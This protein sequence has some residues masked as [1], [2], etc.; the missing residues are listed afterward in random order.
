[1]KIGFLGLLALIFITLKLTGYIT[2]AWVWILSP[3]WIGAI[4]A[5]FIII[6]VMVY[7]LVF[8]SGPRH[9]P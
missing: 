9:L 5:V 2:W 7:S 1:M 6:V 4:G 3:L 8:N